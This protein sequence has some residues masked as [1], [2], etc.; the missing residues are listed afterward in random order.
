[1]S[2]ELVLVLSLIAH[3][4]GDYLIQN[5]YMADNKTSRWLPALVHGF[6]Y[7]IPFLIVTQSLAAL[8]VIS[9]THAIIDRYRLAKYVIWFKNQLV[10]KRARY[11]W[12]D[13][14]TDKDGNFLYLQPHQVN[15]KATGFPQSVPP[16]MAVWLLIIVDN[17]IH[18]VLNTLALVFLGGIWVIW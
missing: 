2:L 5:Q 3:F 11:A 18:I 10:P 17:T 13:S 12:S 15:N 7:T 16:W 8:L 1:M 14:P 9:L 4:V 6:T